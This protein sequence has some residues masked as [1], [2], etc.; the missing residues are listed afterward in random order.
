MAP[1][2]IYSN[3]FYII[4]IIHRNRETEREKKNRDR[5]RETRIFNYRYT[6]ERIDEWDRS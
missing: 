4:Y 3:I 2:V 5:E 1:I 6:H